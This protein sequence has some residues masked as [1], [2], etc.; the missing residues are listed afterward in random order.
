MS[1]HEELENMIASDVSAIPNFESDPELNEL[2]TWLLNSDDAMSVEAARLAVHN[3]AYRHAGFYDT[4]H[5]M[6][7]EGMYHSTKRVLKLMGEAVKE[8]SGY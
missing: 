6:S 7:M 4:G 2:R 5:S 8:S 1:D 3:L